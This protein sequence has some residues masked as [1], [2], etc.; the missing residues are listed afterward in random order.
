MQGE[1]PTC[2]TG[3]DRR[4]TLESSR[5]RR[6]A[7]IKAEA[8]LASDGVPATKAYERDVIGRRLQILWD[9]PRKW[10]TGKVADYTPSS[11]MHLVAYTDGDTKWHNLGEEEGCMPT[12]LRW[13]DDPPAEA[14]ASNRAS[15][16]T[17]PSK[18][19]P[20]AASTAKGRRRS[21]AQGRVHPASW[22]RRRRRNR[23][24]RRTSHSA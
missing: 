4:G 11:E 12:Q 18:A 20:Q 2:G 15:S 17:S 3:E 16:R 7:A 9:K 22:W 8:G 23:W 24:R 13:L 14:K 1:P 6:T 10:F 19:K 5:V 21:Q